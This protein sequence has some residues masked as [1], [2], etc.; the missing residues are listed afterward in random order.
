MS[1]AKALS[2]LANQRF[3]RLGIGAGGA[4][5]TER[6]LATAAG[7]DQS[8]YTWIAGTTAGGAAWGV[9]GKLLIWPIS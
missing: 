4:I 8:M 5:V 3:L 7:V 9:I 1:A 6:V 2:A